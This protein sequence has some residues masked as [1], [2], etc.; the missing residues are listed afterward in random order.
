MNVPREIHANRLACS[1]RLPTLPG[2]ATIGLGAVRRSY[3]LAPTWDECCLMALA[4]CAL[5]LLYWGATGEIPFVAVALGAVAVAY[6]LLR[7]LAFPVQLMF[8]DAGCVLVYPFGRLRLI[9]YCMIR[10]ASGNVIE[11][12]GRPLWLWWNPSISLDEH[13]PEIG[14]LLR[15]LGVVV[16]VASRSHVPRSLALWCIA[17]LLWATGTTLFG[18]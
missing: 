12:G 14:R 18:P 8:A 13:R 11:F 10:A 9:P 3:T 16:G 4:A 15:R 6:P 7:L 17:L 2:G 5:P 1:K